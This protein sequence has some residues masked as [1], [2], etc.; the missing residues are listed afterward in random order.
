MGITKC[1]FIITNWITHCKLKRILNVDN[2]LNVFT[3]KSIKIKPN[4]KVAIGALAKRDGLT[5]DKKISFA[6]LWHYNSILNMR[7]HLKKIKIETIDFWKIIK[8]CNK[9]YEI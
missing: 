8:G 9:Y 4:Y 3:I 2:I 6:I 5:D 7:N 1:F